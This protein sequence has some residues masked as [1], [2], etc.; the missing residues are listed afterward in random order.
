MILGLQVLCVSDRS[1][2]TAGFGRRSLC[3]SVAAAAAGTS[4]VLLTAWLS[5]LGSS[6]TTEKALCGEPRSALDIPKSAEQAGTLVICFTL[7]V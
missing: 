3:F 6:V 4:L 5:L 1:A 2:G 7:A